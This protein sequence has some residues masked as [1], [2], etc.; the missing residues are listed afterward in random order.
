[1]KRLDRRFLDI[2]MKWS[3]VVISIV[4]L[5]YIKIFWL[6][7][8]FMALFLQEVN[9]FL[10]WLADPTKM[11]AEEY[12]ATYWP[13]WMAV[14]I[15]LSVLLTVWYLTWYRHKR[16]HL[17]VGGGKEGRVL[18]LKGVR[19]GLIYDV[20]DAKNYLQWR[21][22]KKP[23]VRIRRRTSD[24]LNGEKVVS[25]TWPDPLAIPL[26][27]PVSMRIIYYSR[28]WSLRILRLMVPNDIDLLSSFRTVQL[29]EGYFVNL[30]DPLSP[31]RTLQ[32]YVHERP[33]YLEYEEGRARGQVLEHLGD[34]KDAVQRSAAANPQLI[35]R[36]YEDG[37]FPI[38]DLEKEEALSDG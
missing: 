7:F 32:A 2:L 34:V 26:G 3:A 35:H 4:I 20:W 29:P 31:G 24:I 17:V 6:V 37:S 22:K 38:L 33:G 19:R 10:T 12:W 8:I 36:D 15:V 13:Y 1:M 30:Q 23:L 5:W 21:H 16:P 14:Y 27:R 28:P 18:W 25:T 9:L 11:G